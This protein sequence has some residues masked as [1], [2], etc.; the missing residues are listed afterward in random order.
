MALFRARNSTQKRDDDTGPLKARSQNPTAPS[1][2]W[3]WEDN[4]FK[5][6]A[7]WVSTQLWQL[8]RTER[9]IQIMAKREDWQQLGSKK[10]RKRRGRGGGW[11]YHISCLPK[12]AQSDF[13]LRQNVT[14][15]ETHTAERAP[16]GVS[17]APRSAT[18]LSARQR[19]VMEARSVVLREVDRR[20]FV[21]RVSRRR[22]ILALVEDA[23]WDLHCVEQGRNDQCV[24][25]P[26]LLQAARDANDRSKG[27]RG[28]VLS[29]RGVYN[30]LEAYEADGAVALAPAVT[31]HRQEHPEWLNGFLRFYCTLAKI[32]IGHALEKYGASLPRDAFVPSYDQAKRALKALRGTSRFLDAHRGREGRLAL[33]ARLGFITRTL[34]GLDPTTIYTADGKTFDALVEHPLHHRPFRPEIT[35][36][37]DVV[38][39][40][41]V[42]WSVGLVEDTVVVAEALRRACDTHGIPAIFYSDRGAGYRN[43]QINHATLGLCA[44][45]GIT[46]THSLPYN[47]QARGLIERVGGTVWNRLA[48]DLPTYM[49]EDMDREARRLV[50]RRVDKEIRQLGASPTLPTFAEFRDA[51]EAAIAAYNDRLH[52]NLRVFNPLTRRH[53]KATPNEVWADFGKRGFEPVPLDAHEADD[54]F[55]PVERRK[56]HRGQV[57]FNTNH[58][59][60]QRLEPFHGMEVL[61]GYDIF[62]ASKVWVRKLEHENGAPVAGALICVACFFNNKHAYVPKSMRDSAVERRARGRLKRIEAHR[63]EALEEANPALRIDHAPALPGTFPAPSTRPAEA[64]TPQAGDGRDRALNPANTAPERTRK[65]VP[66]DQYELAD[67]CI[68]HPGEMTANQRR[69]LVQLFNSPSARELYELKG[70][71]VEDLKNLLTATASGSSELNSIREENSP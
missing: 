38:T 65:Q 52:G 16:T 19:R 69:L 17:L 56:V 6:A 71:R 48:K 25:T 58:Y 24:L 45:L 10:A 15:T 33:K 54:L 49:G 14:N 31:R 50:D 57:S 11:E 40:K 4:E 18:A 55:R 29:L 32:S 1:L 35:T 42:G 59:F 39:R 7:E 61:V 3:T 23:A 21:E 67:H 34:E 46:T 22:A 47:S 27:D 51:A 26:E 64:V 62:D 43:R 12:A 13:L 66:G 37:L 70:G 2:V 8:P 36:V 5:T 53:R 44:R 9:A 60:D 30:W 20:V 28:K 63:R 68:A 41:I